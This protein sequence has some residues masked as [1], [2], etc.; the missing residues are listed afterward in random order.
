MLYIHHCHDTIYITLLHTLLLGLH[1]LRSVDLQTELYE[2]VGKVTMSF[3][4]KWIV[5]TADWILYR[6]EGKIDRPNQ[7]LD[8]FYVM[9]MNGDN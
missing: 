8:R 5:E 3:C 1:N 4:I 6:G 9:S 2:G 7:F